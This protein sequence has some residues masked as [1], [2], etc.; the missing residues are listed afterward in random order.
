MVEAWLDRNT[1]IGAWQYTIP[2]DATPDTVD[3]DRFL[4][5]APKRPFEPIRLFRWRNY[6]DYGTGLAGDLYVH[7]LTGLHVVTGSLGPS[8]VFGTGATRFWKDGR[9]APDVML[10]LL[11]YP[12]SE[13]HPEFTFALR[14]NFASGV[15]E[16][17]FGLRFVGSGGTMNVSMTQLTLSRVPRETEPGMMIGSFAKATQEQIVKAYREKYPEK[18]ATPE[19]LRPTSQEVFTAP[20]SHN[21]HQE[22]HNNFYN[23]VRTRKPFFE[24]AVFG[25]RTA[26]PALLCNM[27]MNEK[28]ICH[29]DPK[30]FIAS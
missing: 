22:H 13:A 21:P 7:L 6:D 16:E 20:R 30:T 17:G 1:A 18:K 14:V 10:A 15:G 25:Y 11:D 27:S 23:A 9:D 26:G 12:K 4:G 3:W 19:T 28:R 2:P 29:W 5:N 24:D 8:R